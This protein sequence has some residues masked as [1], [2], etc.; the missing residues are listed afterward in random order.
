MSCI[1]LTVKALYSHELTTMQLIIKG[2]LTL[3]RVLSRV[4]LL[5]I[6]LHNYFKMKIL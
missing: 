6:F 2:I 1:I 3:G 4:N 5:K